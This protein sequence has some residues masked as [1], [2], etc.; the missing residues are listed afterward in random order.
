MLLHPF[1][2]LR[3]NKQA[4][5]RREVGEVLGGDDLL[6]AICRIGATAK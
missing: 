1:G 5:L 6:V 2:E 3:G 4:R